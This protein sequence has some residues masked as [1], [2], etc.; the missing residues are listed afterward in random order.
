MIGIIS[1][2]L[3]PFVLLIMIH[4]LQIVIHGALM[5]IDV[6]PPDT[7]KLAPQLEE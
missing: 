1:I 2:C 6:A 4:S 7:E 5:G 3:L